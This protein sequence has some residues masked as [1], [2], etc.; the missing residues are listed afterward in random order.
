MVV[1]STLY[2]DESVFFTKLEK[3]LCKTIFHGLKS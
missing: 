2:G 1:L 3:V